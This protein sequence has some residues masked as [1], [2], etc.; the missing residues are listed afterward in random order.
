MSGQKKLEE[1]NEYVDGLDKEIGLY[2]FVYQ[3]DVVK[4]LSLTEMELCSISVEKC[5]EI[6]LILTSYSLFLKKQ[7][8]RYTII[9]SKLKSILD[10]IVFSEIHNYCDD[11]KFVKYEEKIYKVCAGNDVARELKESLDDILS[12]KQ[13]LEFMSTSVNNV[14]NMFIELKRS[15]Y[16][17][18]A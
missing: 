4:Y 3:S 18:Q 13:Y 9:L 16:V 7:E 17:K 2:G 5:S 6:A 12:K 1:V 8:N 11:P 14:S 15:K 10:K